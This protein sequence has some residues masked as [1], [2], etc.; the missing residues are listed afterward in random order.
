[1]PFKSEKQRRYLWANEPE[2]ARDWTDTYGSRIQKSNGGIMSIQGGVEN[3]EPSQMINAPIR[4]KSS[5]NHPTAHLAY[6]TPEEQDIL[7]DLN[8][9]GSLNGKPN[10][11]PAGIPSLQGDFGEPGG[12]YGGHEGQDVSGSRDTGTGNY[13]RSTRPADVAAQKEF[14]ASY[15]ITGSRPLGQRIGQGIRNVWSDVKNFAQKGGMWG[16]LT[17]GLGSLF[18]P[19]SSPRELGIMNQYRGPGG[20]TLS[21]KTDTTGRG[22]GDGRDIMPLWAQLGYPSYET[23]LA[24]QNQGISGIEGIDLEDETEVDDFI[25]RFKLADAYRQQPGT[26]DTPIKYTSGR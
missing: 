12:A 22:N 2:I 8:L 10:R 1:M 9:Y 24:A 3:Y 17:K 20:S 5:P 7:I 18:G 16:A 13:E 21:T 4:A 6:I 14:D 25:Q 15:G 11:G 23:F 19:K 26:I